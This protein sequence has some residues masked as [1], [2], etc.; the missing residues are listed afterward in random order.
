MTAAETPMIVR[1]KLNGWPESDRLSGS[2]R[3]L[4]DTCQQGLEGLYIASMDTANQRGF[5]IYE[6]L[7]TMLIIGIVMSIAVPNLS[8]FTKS[9][10]MTSVANDLH[11]S[12]H[13]ARSEAARSKSN[14]TIC[15]SSNSMDAAAACGGTF[16]DG[17]IIFIDLGIGDLVRDAGAGENVLR[18]YPAIPDSINIITNGG[19]D[20]FGFAKT[21]L[22]RGDVD[23]NLALSIAMICDQRGLDIAAGGRATA[24]RLVITPIGRATVISDYDDI[25]FAGGDCP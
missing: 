14:I 21:G 18:A 10:R 13:L 19:A 22:G 6:L 9:S 20:Y 15:A 25:I 4:S 23:G 12:F 2:F 11:S 7:I 17:W 8:D 1:I 24:R 16:N 3:R 5:T